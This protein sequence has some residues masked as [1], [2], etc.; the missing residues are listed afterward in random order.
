MIVPNLCI[1]KFYFEAADCIASCIQQQFDQPGYRGIAV[2]T[3]LNLH[4]LIFLSDN[5]R[6]EVTLGMCILSTSQL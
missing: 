1:G 6:T 5:M 4:L 2:V 3:V